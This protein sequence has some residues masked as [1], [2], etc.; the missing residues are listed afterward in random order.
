MGLKTFRIHEVWAHKVSL[1]KVNGLTVAVFDPSAHEHYK[2]GVIAENHAFRTFNGLESDEKTLTDWILV[3]LLPPQGYKMS[4]AKKRRIAETML[5]NGIMVNGVL[6]VR[7]I[8]SASQTRQGN[9][10]FVRATLDRDV[11]RATLNYGA[12][13]VVPNLKKDGTLRN[14]ELPAS[15]MVTSVA[16]S[17]T[18]N[19]MAQST[20]YPTGLFLA[21]PVDFTVP[22]GQPYHADFLTYE[23]VSDPVATIS[24]DLFGVGMTEMMVKPADGMGTIRPLAALRVCRRIA[25]LRGKVIIPA[26]VL[27]YLEASIIGKGFV[28]S[29][30]GDAEFKRLWLAYAPS[31]LQDRGAGLKGISAVY[32]HDELEGKHVDLVVTDSQWKYSYAH[33]LHPEFLVCQWQKPAKSNLVKL[34]YQFTQALA[35]RKQDGVALAMQGLGFTCDQVLT[36]PSAAK[37]FLGL[38]SGQEE[39]DTTRKEVSTLTRL[40]IAN[41]EMLHDIYAQQKLT[42]LMERHVNDMALGRIPVEGAYRYIICD[43]RV[44]FGKASYLQKG[45]QFLNGVVDTFAAFRSPLIHRSE[46]GLLGTVSVPEWEELGLFRDILVLSPKDDLQLRCGGADVD[47]DKFLV[48]RNA[49]L[50]A[51]VTPCPLMMNSS[52]EGVY[53]E[54]TWANILKADLLSLEGDLIGRITNASSSISDWANHEI[55]RLAAMG[56]EPGVDEYV[57]EPGNSIEELLAAAQNRNRRQASADDCLI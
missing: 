19:G 5:R 13:F 8:R 1:S 40:L 28:A 48:T 25:E 11:V 37:A 29:M 45:Q 57:A 22:A 18:R 30:K 9:A 20:T 46:C 3:H 52:E 49:T 56:F 24:F 38:I 23:V 33:G 44:I 12:T 14:P 4:R 34:N 50:M 54:Y 39:D 41:E 26:D 6:Y 2:P 47:G 43:P 15:A 53:E 35:L 36:N 51:A 21:K 27:A 55:E 16:K 32:P 10:L 17:E 31:L 7:C 42:A